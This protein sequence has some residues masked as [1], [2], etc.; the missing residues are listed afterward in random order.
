MRVAV[1]DGGR[2]RDRPQRCDKHGA[3]CLSVRRACSSFADNEQALFMHVCLHVPVRPH[4]GQSLRPRSRARPVERLRGLGR[5]S[6]TAFTAS[7]LSTC[8]AMDA[9]APH[10]S[11][12]AAFLSCTR[13][14]D[15]FVQFE[16]FRPNTL[17]TPI[18]LAAQRKINK[19]RTSYDNNHSISFLPAITSTSTRMHSKFLLLPSLQAHQETED[20]TPA[21]WA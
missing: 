3:A 5:M 21:S 7:N 8:L 16:H 17:D 15:N 6:R 9:L 1:R 11:K 12:T 13:P 20:S 14:P 10:P 18:N 4:S 19:D 2:L